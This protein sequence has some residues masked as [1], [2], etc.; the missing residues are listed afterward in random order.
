M[1]ATHDVEYRGYKI[2]A[3]AA[4]LDAPYRGKFIVVKADNVVTPVVRGSV[5]DLPSYSAARV[6]A[7]DAG[8]AAVDR[9]LSSN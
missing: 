2:N 4:G 6:R 9:L 8:K 3:Y 1:V 7:L 5:E